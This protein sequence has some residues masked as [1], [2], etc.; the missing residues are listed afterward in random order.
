MVALIR[1]IFD[2]LKGKPSPIS[3]LVHPVA[4]A[5][6]GAFC[7]I[8]EEELRQSEII[9]NVTYY[10]NIGT[11]DVGRIDTSFA[12]VSFVIVLTPG[13]D[14][15]QDL[16][17]R[18]KK[19]RSKI[20]SILLFKVSNASELKKERSISS[21][22]WKFI[23]QNR[24]E[25]YHYIDAIP[26]EYDRY[27]IGLTELVVDFKT[28]FTLPAEEL[29]RQCNQIGEAG[30]QRRCRLGDLW[31]EDLQRRAMTYM[32]RVGLPNPRDQT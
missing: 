24:I 28:Y 1:S 14:L 7:C 26:S 23:T 31:R 29:Y 16:K 18:K 30:A 11:D 6:S 21:S 20:H 5:S 9:S 13:C 12:K 8:N 17:D 15:L 25:K 27:R 2:C 32:L 10:Q 4:Q 3:E 22:E 19:A